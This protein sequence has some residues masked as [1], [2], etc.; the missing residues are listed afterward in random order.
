MRIQPLLSGNFGE[1]RS[2]TFIQGLIS[3]HNRKQA[4]RSTRLPMAGSP[5]YAS[6][7]MASDTPSTWIIPA[8]IPRYTATSTASPPH[9]QP[10]HRAAIRQGKLRVGHALPAPALPV[11]RGQLIAYSGNSGS[12]A[13]LIYTLKSEMPPHRTSWI[14]SSGTATNFRQ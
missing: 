1:L 4:F 12:S 11:K 5:G 2:I 14:P 7:P 6:V 9:R 3:R 10:G 13:A 8:A